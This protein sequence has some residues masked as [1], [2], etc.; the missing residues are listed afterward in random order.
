MYSYGKGLYES[1]KLRVPR[2]LMPYVPL[3]PRPLD[4]HVLRA[5]H[6]VLYVFSCPTC[7]Y[8]SRVSYL[9]CSRAFFPT[10]SHASRDSCTT[11]LVHYVLLHSTCLVLK[12]VSCPACLESYMLSCPAC[13]ESYMLS[14]LTCL[15]S[16]VLSCPVCSCAFRTLCLTCLVPYVPSCF[17]S[18]F[19]LRTLSTSYLM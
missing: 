14:C 15:V 13:L 1:S 9:A 10:R 5:L 6:I 4:P 17:M 12:V 3:A 2:A 18:P 8:A 16:Y 11:F 7:S 19:S